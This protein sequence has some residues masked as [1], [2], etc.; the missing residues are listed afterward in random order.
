MNKIVLLPPQCSKC[1]HY[2]VFKYEGVSCDAFPKGIPE[3]LIN[4]LKVIQKNMVK[5]KEQT[6]L[7][8]RH[9]NMLIVKLQY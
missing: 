3:D 8:D 2:N 1:K 6:N 4:H 7:K 9:H 5:E